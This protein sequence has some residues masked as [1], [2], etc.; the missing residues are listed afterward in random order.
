MCVALLGLFVALGGTTWAAVSLPARSVGTAQLKTGAVT[1]DKIKLHAVT[2]ETVKDHSLTGADI[3]LASLGAVPQ[4][5]HAA[6]ADSATQATSA[7]SATHAK[8]AD[9]AGTAYSTAVVNFGQIPLVPTV[10]ASLH[11]GAGS[12]FLASKGQVDAY[13]NHDIVGCDLTAGTD[14]DTSFVQPAENMHTSEI[15]V[16]NLVHT[17]ASADTVNLT[18]FVAFGTTA[19][20]SQVRITA[21]QVGSI[22]T[23]P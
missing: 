14:K 9:A 17:F 4:A 19:N 13:Y 21:V 5:A 20:L 7:D 18:C 3:K 23:T 11:V 2:G 8:T 6:S 10:V 15:V 16:N 1:G 12:Y 22:V